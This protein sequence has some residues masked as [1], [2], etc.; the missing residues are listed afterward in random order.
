M[1]PRRSMLDYRNSIQIVNITNFVLTMKLLAMYTASN[2]FINM[3]S[4]VPLNSSR[5]QCK[6]E[7]INEWR[8][9][10]FQIQGNMIIRKY[11]FE[12][13]GLPLFSKI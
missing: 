1:I 11:F 12:I 2:I 4:N 6:L 5:M 3:I 8:L 13:F 7:A 9:K 10:I